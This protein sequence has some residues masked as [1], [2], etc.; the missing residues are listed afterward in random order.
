M[1]KVVLIYNGKQI[2]SVSGFTGIDSMNFAELALR[3]NLYEF[4]I[5]DSTGKLHREQKEFTRKLSCFK[6]R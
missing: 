1:K 2:Y 5:P 3:N 4:F 6:H